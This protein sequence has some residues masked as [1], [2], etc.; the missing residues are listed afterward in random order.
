MNVSLRYSPMGN[1][2]ERPIESADAVAHSYSFGAGG[3]NIRVSYRNP[4]QGAVLSIGGKPAELERLA[5]EIL[6]SVAL[7]KL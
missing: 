5:H 2:Y 6:A 3:E 4:K 7:A 1:C